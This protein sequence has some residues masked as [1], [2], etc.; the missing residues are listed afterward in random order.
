MDQPRWV[1]CVDDDIDTCV[2][3]AFSLA[4]SG[5]LVETAHS[6]EE[7]LRQ[8]RQKEFVL[9]SIDSRLP[10]GSGIE[11]CKHIR[12][13]DPHTPILFYSGAAFPEEIQKAMNAGA[14]AYLVKPTDP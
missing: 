11:L 2:L 7:A 8:A 3:M 4:R 5:Y 13:F 6:I 12:Q 10:D 9:Y 14:Q 1:L